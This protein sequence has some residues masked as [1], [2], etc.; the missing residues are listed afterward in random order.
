[1]SQTNV[2]IVTRVF[3]AWN[4]GNL[5]DV[6]PFVAAG[7]EWLEVE[8][9]PDSTGAEVHGKAQVRSMLES[10]YDTWQHYRLEPEEVRAVGEDRVVAVL[11]EVARGRASG[12]DVA[13]RWGYVITLCDGQLAR[14]EAYRNPDHA[15]EAA[16]LLG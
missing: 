2:E 9:V 5:E 3:A 8:G 1:M 14:V 6:L 15:L 12:V 4:E 13:S 16:G 11:R 7:I 10:L